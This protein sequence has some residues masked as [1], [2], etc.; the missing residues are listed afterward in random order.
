ME[1]FH[2]SDEVIM[3]DIYAAREKNEGKIHS[4]DFAKA[5][6][7]NGISARYFAEFEQVCDYIE[8]NCPKGRHCP[9]D[10]GRHQ[11]QAV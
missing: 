7:Q 8:G 11:Q 6:N 1:A 5:M 9:G 3:V 10:W 2:G 4:K